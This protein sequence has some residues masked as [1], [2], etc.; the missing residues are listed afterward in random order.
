MGA[1]RSQWRAALASRYFKATEVDGETV[2]PQRNRGTESN[3][4]DTG[5]PPACGRRPDREHPRRSQA[6]SVHEACVFVDVHDP[7]RA[8]RGFTRGVLMLPAVRHLCSSLFLCS[9]VAKL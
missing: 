8:K 3:R 4:G 9:S 1:S 5:E 2:T 7:S 6:R